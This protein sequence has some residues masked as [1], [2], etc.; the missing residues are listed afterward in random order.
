[1]GQQGIFSKPIPAKRKRKRGRPAKTDLPRL[2]K[3]Q[4]H[5]SKKRRLNDE[6]L[7]NSA[8]TNSPVQAGVVEAGEEAGRHS[9]VNKDHSRGISVLKPISENAPKRRGR[10]PKKKDFTTPSSQRILEE[11]VPKQSN[12]GFQKGLDVV[13]VP[14]SQESLDSGISKRDRGRLPQSKGLIPSL[15]V[16][17]GD[18]IS[19]SAQEKSILRKTV[20]KRGPG[21]PRK[22][23]KILPSVEVHHERLVRYEN[24]AQ[25]ALG[26]ATQKSGCGRP[27]KTGSLQPSLESQ[28]TSETPQTEVPANKGRKQ[29]RK[30][31]TVDDSSRRRPKTTERVLKR[32]PGRS[33]KANIPAALQAE[34]TT[35]SGGVVERA[36]DRPAKD[37]VLS[38]SQESRVVPDTTAV[39]KR[40]GRP[41][42]NKS[43]I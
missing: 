20:K 12:R 32:G 9:S 13:S 29:P 11:T 19:N 18:Q 39:K 42:K 33:R 23:E 24:R 8:F 34:Q 2:N 40:R 5:P 38:Q 30:S 37:Q 27:R 35:L 41:P 21:R 28:V 1:M 7:N 31:Y 3:S 43:A 17:T 36:L 26:E 10:P 25:G 4:L 15:A 16:E 6:S 22:T 14:D